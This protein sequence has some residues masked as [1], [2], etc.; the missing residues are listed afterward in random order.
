MGDL[1]T[2]EKEQHSYRSQNSDDPRFAGR[3]TT[4]PPLLGGEGRGEDGRC[5]RQL[6]R[7]VFVQDFLHRQGDDDFVAAFHFV[8]R[9][10]LVADATL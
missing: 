10:F 1:L 5:S 3:L 8:R 6:L 4:I 9:G 2:E 7:N